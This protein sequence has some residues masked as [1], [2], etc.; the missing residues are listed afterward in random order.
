MEAGRLVF[1][2]IDLQS[3]DAANRDAQRRRFGKIMGKQMCE[4][5]CFAAYV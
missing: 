2:R 5:L 3:D 1:P 4:S